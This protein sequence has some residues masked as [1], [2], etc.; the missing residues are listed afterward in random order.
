MIFDM[1][2]CFSFVLATQEVLKD[3]VVLAAAMDG[4]PQLS[5]LAHYA[6]R[7]TALGKAMGRRRSE[8]EAKDMLRYKG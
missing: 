2:S 5:Q 7:A 1:V 3:P 6:R 4:D 8:D